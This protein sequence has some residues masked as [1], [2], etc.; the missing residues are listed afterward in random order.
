MYLHRVREKR[1]HSTC[2][3]NFAKRW[4]ISKSFTSSLSSTFPI[5]QSL[6]I[7]PNLKRVATLPCKMLVLN[8][9]NDPELSEANFHARFNHSKQ[10]LKNIHSMTLA[11]IYSPIKDIYRCEKHNFLALRWR[12][13]D[14]LCTSLALCVV[15]PSWFSACT[16]YALKLVADTRRTNNIVS[17]T[18]SPR[19]YRQQDKH[20]YLFLQ[21]ILTRLLLTTS[22]SVTTVDHVTGPHS[23]SWTY[24]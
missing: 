2:A 1:W 4:P 14:L 21:V 19:S 24:L 12:V 9:R 11:S 3:S 13:C 6:N 15:S 10:L 5:T 7:P 16:L 18:L 17:M 8:N 22:R 23:L 20:N